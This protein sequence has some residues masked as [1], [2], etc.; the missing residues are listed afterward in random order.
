MSGSPDTTF[1]PVADDQWPVVAW[2]WQAFQQD[3]APVLDALPYADGRYQWSRLA[4]APG[5]DIAGYLAWRPHPNTGEQAPVGFS[6]VTRVAQPQRVLTAFW[7]APAAR[8]GGLGLA[9][10]RHTV[11]AH[12]GPWAIP[13]QDNNV[14]AA[15][16]WRRVADEAFGPGGWTQTARL[17]PGK[18]DVPPDQWIESVTT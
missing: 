1:A 4:D 3:L 16:F 6:V 5:P 8:H 2:L 14:G 10:A 17:V 13:F 7:V 11:A 12:P 9:L 15:A 18:P